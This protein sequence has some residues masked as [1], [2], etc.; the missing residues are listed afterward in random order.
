MAGCCFCPGTETKTR[1][2]NEL[3]LLRFI[4]GRW[5]MPETS[6]VACLKRLPS[7]LPRTGRGSFFAN[8]SRIRLCHKM[9]CVLRWMWTD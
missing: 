2:S 6:A 4:Y 8:E 7:P 1:A 5:R 3:R 9:A